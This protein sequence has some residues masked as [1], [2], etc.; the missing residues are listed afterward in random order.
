M[1]TRRDSKTTLTID[2]FPTVIAD[3]AY[4]TITTHRAE[5]M[6]RFLNAFYLGV[7][8]SLG[9]FLTLLVGGILNHITQ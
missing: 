7:S 5:M 4:I 9:S 8:F 3:D 2:N 6:K 1:I